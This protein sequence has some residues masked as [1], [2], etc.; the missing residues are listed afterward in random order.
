LKTTLFT[1]GLKSALLVLLCLCAAWPALASNRM[2]SDGIR[3]VDEVSVRVLGSTTLPSV[4]IAPI[5]GSF[6]VQSENGSYSRRTGR[7]VVITAIGN[8]VEISIDGRNERLASIRFLPEAGSA[9]YLK[10]HNSNHSYAGELEVQSTSKGLRILNIVPLE[11][12]VASVVGSEYGLDDLEGAKAMA[13]VARTYALY[14]LE[15]GKE[16]RDHEGFQ[17]YGGLKRATPAARRAAQQTAGQVL[18]H[19][20]NLIEAVYSASN[21][22]RTASNTTIWGSKPLPYLK[23]RKDSWDSKSPYASWTWTVSEKELHRALTASFGLKVKDIHILEEAGDGRIE[24]VRLKG[25]KSSKDVTGTAFRAAVARHFGS[26]SLRSTLFSANER[27]G[28]YTFKGK[29]FG[30]GVGLSQWGAH[31]MALDGKSFSQILDFYYADTQL[32]NRFGDESSRHA[33]IELP[34]LTSLSYSKDEND[35]TP[36]QRVSGQMETPKEKRSVFS[37]KNNSAEKQTE[38]IW[39]HGKKTTKRKKSKGSKRSGW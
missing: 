34:V 18:E 8:Q 9:L 30:H 24:S 12:Y 22:G 19:K 4:R 33:R 32:D 38:N 27:R 14:A 26:K 6:V 2:T 36:V 21:G 17:V 31:F 7:E 1:S 10:T 16:L 13:V 35:S 25:N 23:S 3:Y 37:K 20:G 11:D 29:G 39:K 15:N 5:S 28:T